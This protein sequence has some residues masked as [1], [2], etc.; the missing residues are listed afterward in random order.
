MY[1]EIM[2]HNE[3]HPIKYRIYLLPEED[4]LY[5]ESVTDFKIAIGSDKIPIPITFDLEFEKIIEGDVMHS[6]GKV[7]FEYCCVEKR[8]VVEE[9]GE[10][11]VNIYGRLC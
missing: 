5:H 11:I 8:T 7:K 10:K 6:S 1:L 2:N 4:V 9:E 3:L